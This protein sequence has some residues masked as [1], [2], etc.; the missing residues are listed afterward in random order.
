MN[1][2]TF[3]EKWSFRLSPMNVFVFTGTILLSL[4][5]FVIYITAF[6]PLREYIPGYADVGMQKDL[7]HLSIQVDT[8]EK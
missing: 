3:E 7:W 6:T 4:I 1:D 2:D 5:T 8:L